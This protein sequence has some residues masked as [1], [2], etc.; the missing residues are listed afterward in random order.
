M[1]L[2]PWEGG[3][4][5]NSSDSSPQYTEWMGFH[6]TSLDS[7]QRILEENYRIST[8]LDD[9]LGSGA[10]FFIEGFTDPVDNAIDWAKFRSWDPEARSRKY[11]TYAVL[12][13]LIRTKTHLDLDDVEDLK[14]FNQLRAAW[15]VR[16]RQEGYTGNRALENDCHL[17]NFVL[18]KLKLDALVRREAITSRRGQMRTRIPNCRIMCLREPTRCAI[19]H[20]I[21]TKGS[22]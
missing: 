14:I 17:A 6:G 5:L 13:S 12:K 7:A 20:D 18:H 2:K 8:K 9:W 3:Y 19:K 1:P 15:L 4:P 10:Y 22:I 11:R 21:V 16:I